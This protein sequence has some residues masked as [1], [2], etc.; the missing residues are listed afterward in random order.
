MGGHQLFQSVGS[1]VLDVFVSRT[2]LHGD[3][4]DAVVETSL[5]SFCRERRIKLNIFSWQNGLVKL[6]DV[7]VDGNE[8]NIDVAM[9]W[10]HSLTINATKSGWF[11][12]TLDQFCS[13]NF[14]EIIL[15]LGHLG[16]D[17]VCSVSCNN[18]AVL[19]HGTAFHIKYFWNSLQNS[20]QCPP[21]LS[22]QE[23]QIVDI[24]N[25]IATMSC[26]SFG[27][28]QMTTEATACPTGC[29][30]WPVICS[31]PLL[32]VSANPVYRFFVHLCTNSGNQLYLRSS[33]STTYLNLPREHQPVLLSR[34]LSLTKCPHEPG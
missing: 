7:H 6:C 5:R 31:Q 4:F 33:D 10:L 1:D 32:D 2:L 16:I 30:V 25:R 12:E 19:N 28:V 9:K 27:I 15:L 3:L 34:T 8:R 14:K 24:L 21:P 22:C 23:Q 11:A 29:K 18:L 26:G 13:D 20:T 17:E